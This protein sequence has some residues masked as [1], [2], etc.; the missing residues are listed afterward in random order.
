MTLMLGFCILAPLADAIAKLL[1]DRVPIAQL[2]FF[3]FAIQL[4]VL[5]PLMFATGRTWQM[6]R[7]VCALAALRTVMHIV[8]IAMMVTAVRHLPLADAV[9]IAFIMP[10]LI[11]ILGKLLLNEEVGLRRLGACAVGFAGTLM[12]VQPAFQTFGWPAL[13][14]LGVAVNFSLFM[15]ATR[16]MARDIDAISLQAVSGL[17]AVVIVGPVLLVMP[18]GVAAELA[19]VGFPEGTT[20]L[21]LGMGVIGTFAHL[22]MTWSLRYA[23]GATLAPMQYLELPFAMVLGFV[24]FNELPNPLATVGICVIMAAGL[25]IFIRERAT[26]RALRG[27]LAPEPGA[28]PAAE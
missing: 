6:T 12:V 27:D 26:Q 23:P 25:F 24:L 19:W 3:R 13:L 8:G 9:A 17:M 21:L 11:L 10:F 15:I 7:A 4:A 28:I 1:G 14:P 2:V 16:R 20:G 22:L 18:A 5:A